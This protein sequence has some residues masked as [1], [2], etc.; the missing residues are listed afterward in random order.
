M[1]KD[2]ETETVKKT[3]RTVRK[4]VDSTD[5]KNTA[6]RKAL[7]E[8]NDDDRVGTILRNER[9]KKGYELEDVA[10][11][12]CI[13]SGYMEA[14]ESGNYKA[15]PQMPYSAGFVCAYAKFLGLNHARITQLFREEI[16]VKPKNIQTFLPEEAP[17]EASVPSKVY[18]IAG[19]VVIALLAALWGIFSP[20]KNATDQQPAKVETN[21]ETVDNNVGKVEY[22]GADEEQKNIVEKSVEEVVNAENTET[23]SKELPTIVVPQEEVSSSQIVV[24]DESYVD[25]SASKV[26]EEGVEVKITSG[27]V[28]IEVKDANKIYLSKVLKAG[29]SYRL[30]KVKGLLLSAGKHVGVEV[31][32]NGKLTPVIR[33]DRKMKI[34]VDGLLKANH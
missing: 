9:L 27:D 5:V 34:D 23:D 13:R 12:L 11:K 29:S 2:K 24:S 1:T 31:Y 26:E 21:E 28:W 16:H 15:L 3:A 19:L 18:V 22:F 14:I 4:T 32:V 30:P 8:T 20:T 10:K 33:R 6:T 17:S 7:P 25:D